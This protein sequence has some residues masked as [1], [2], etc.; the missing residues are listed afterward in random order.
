MASASAELMD[1]FTSL[2][3][4]LLLSSLASLIL[5]EIK[6]T[7]ISLIEHERKINF[8]RNGREPE[9]QPSRIRFE[10]LL[11]TIEAHDKNRSLTHTTLE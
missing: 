3:T 9:E 5:S 10:Y 7:P 8:W 4:E 6:I 11:H 1:S 2:F